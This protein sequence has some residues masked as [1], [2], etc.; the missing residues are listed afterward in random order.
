M[1][2]N[3][4]SKHIGHF[5]GGLGVG[6]D[7]KWSKTRKWKMKEK[8]IQE[9]KRIYKIVVFTKLIKTLRFVIK[10]KKSNID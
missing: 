5:K 3:K 9:F 8:S 10:T 1:N 4:F 2:L 7:E 6:S